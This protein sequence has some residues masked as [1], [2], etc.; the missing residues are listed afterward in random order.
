MGRSALA[1]CK[2]RLLSRGALTVVEGLRATGEEKIRL[3]G[4]AERRWDS[5]EEGRCT[6]RTTAAA[7]AFCLSSCCQVRRRHANIQ[8]LGFALDAFHLRH[9]S[10]IRAKH[11]AGHHA[12][13][14]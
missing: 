4:L 6:F 14:R 13:D 8:S 1:G 2:G 12:G 9:R 10:V 3:P 11:P 7:A 5:W